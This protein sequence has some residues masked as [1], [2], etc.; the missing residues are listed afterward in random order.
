MTRRRTFL[1]LLGTTAVASA[2]NAGAADESEERPTEPG[3]TTDV[4]NVTGF[5]GVT[6]PNGFGERGLPTTV[7]SVG[8]AWEETTVLAVAR[9]YERRNDRVDHA[10]LIEAF[11]GY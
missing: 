4:A 9:E 3:A 8:R 1:A 7:E 5:P 11:E 6:T 10:T 2:T